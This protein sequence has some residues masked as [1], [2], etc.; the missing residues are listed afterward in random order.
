MPKIELIAMGPLPTTVELKRVMSRANRVQS[1]YQ[2]VLGDPLKHLGVP[3]NDGRYTVT[4]LAA[5]LEQRRVLSNA[6]ATVG[7]VDCP[8]VDEL[9]SAVDKA[10]RTVVVSTDDL[11]AILTRTNSSRNQFVLVEI[12]AQLLTIDYRRQTGITPEPNVCAPPWHKEG[13]ACLFDYCDN[14][15]Q[16]GRK[17]IAPQLCE[18]CRSTLATSNIRESVIAACI[19]IVRDAV[20]ANTVVVVRRILGDPIG[21]FIFGGLFLLAFE[22]LF[23]AMGLA[24]V[25][26][27]GVLTLGLLSVVFR[28]LRRARAERL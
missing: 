23:A 26:V 15:P 20:R 14:R 27:V 19:H 12:A 28:Q 13:R 6:E 21:R 4:E 3:D 16:T 7:V 2:F 11:D 24:R 10:A 17:L 9:F 22:Q 1:H 25:Y 18:Q 5:L 8:L